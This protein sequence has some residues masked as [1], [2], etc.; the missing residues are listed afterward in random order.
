MN[1]CNSCAFL[2]ENKDKPNKI[3]RECDNM[4]WY[5]QENLDRLWRDARKYGQF[6]SCH[7]TDPTYIGEKSKKFLAC[8]GFTMAVFMHVKILEGVDV[9]YHKYVEIVGTDNAIPFKAMGEL[10]FSLV[11]KRAD[12]LGKMKI[13]DEISEVRQMR[14]PTGFEKVI[15]AYQKYKDHEPAY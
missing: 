10:A 12:L 15:E 7:S 11:T 14:Y 1:C 5:S 13:P 6:L 9:D 3:L 4:E 2:E 8:T